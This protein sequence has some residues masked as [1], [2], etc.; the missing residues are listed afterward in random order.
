MGAILH[1][2]SMD[3]LFLL[4]KGDIFQDTPKNIML[5]SDCRNQTFF[6]AST[7]FLLLLLIISSKP[8]VLIAS[9]VDLKKISL[10]HYSYC[11]EITTIWVIS[12]SLFS[13]YKFTFY[14]YLNM[15]FIL[16]FPLL[17]IMDCVFSHIES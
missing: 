12:L 7:K 2:L 6:V 14:M 10:I 16:V 8:D 3:N 15:I 4:P 9:F 17:N 11:P 13:V 1:H 5:H